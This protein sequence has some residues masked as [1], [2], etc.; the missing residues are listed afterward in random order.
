MHMLPVSTSGIENKIYINS[1]VVSFSPKK[2]VLQSL[3]VLD[4]LPK[5]NFFRLAIS[6]CGVNYFEQS[7]SSFGTYKSSK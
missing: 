5:Q 6:K 1:K 7:E 3:L 4:Y 2:Y